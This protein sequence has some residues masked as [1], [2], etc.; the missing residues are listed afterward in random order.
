MGKEEMKWHLLQGIPNGNGQPKIYLMLTEINR[1]QFNIKQLQ[2]LKQKS[3]EIQPL[4]G[5]TFIHGF[6]LVD[7]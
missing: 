7:R 2:P 5:P 6:Q 1:H 4:H 3:I